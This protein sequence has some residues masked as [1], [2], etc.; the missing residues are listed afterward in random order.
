MATPLPTPPTM[1]DPAQFPARADTFL[2]AMVPAV[3]EFAADFA[4]GEAARPAVMAALGKDAAASAAAASAA[5][6]LAAAQAVGSTPYIA[7]P[8]V[9]PTLLLDFANGQA[10]DPRITFTRNSA[11]TRINRMGLIELS[12][13]DTPRFEHNPVTGLCR[14]LLV[15]EQRTNIVLN[16]TI[17]GANLATQGVTVTAQ[18][19][20]LSFYGTGTITLSGAS[21]AGPLTG[22]GN[23]PTRS[24]LTFTPSAGT[25]TLTVSGTVQ[26]AQLEPGPF[27]TS[28]IPTAGA[29]VT[30]APDVVVLGGA[31]FAACYKQT[32]W[33]MLA[34]YSMNVSGGAGGTTQ[35]SYVFG[36]N[37]SGVAG[38]DGYAL[39]VLLNAPD[40]PRIR[41]RNVLTV[42]TATCAY[43][44]YVAAGQ[45]YRAAAAMSAA[46]LAVTADGKAVGSTANTVF[47]LDIQDQLLIGFGDTGGEFPYYLNG[48]IRMLAFHPARLP[49][50]QLR[51]LTNRTMS[52]PPP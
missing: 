25:L 17:D 6:S 43:N 7:H 1:A 33:T 42:P 16:S 20:T 36:V 22:S 23:Y 10:L 26:Y 45:A 38:F 31:A 41:G 9:R 11:A 48:C 52:I 12:A 35:S 37:G 4:V 40:H 46:G 3:P 28:Y 51:D 21:T 27:A 30:R 47:G 2:A 13:L 24:T 50:Q 5:A 44:S 15:E 19:Y 18:A 39:S 29:T 8:N 32:E 49:D 34:E 14:G